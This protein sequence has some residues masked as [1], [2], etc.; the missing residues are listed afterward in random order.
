M[1]CLK[2]KQLLICI[3]LLKFLTQLGAHVIL[4]FANQ[5]NFLIINY[6]YSKLS[7]L[8]FLH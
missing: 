4:S 1:I 7:E 6:Y 5:F 2:E 8:N 3:N